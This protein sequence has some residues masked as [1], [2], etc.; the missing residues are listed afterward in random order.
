[1][2]AG[3]CNVVSGLL[4][5]GQ[6]PTS[7]AVITIEVVACLQAVGLT[8]VLVWKRSERAEYTPKPTWANNDDDGTFALSASDDEDE[9]EETA[10]LQPRDSG[11]LEEE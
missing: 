8:W 1:M 5:R 4:L 11:S 6:K 10:Y 3:W 9:M 7:A 2:V